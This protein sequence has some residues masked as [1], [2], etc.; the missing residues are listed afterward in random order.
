[1]YWVSGEREW[2]N[3]GMGWFV[4]R[5]LERDGGYTPHEKEK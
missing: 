1:M 2:R 4:G 3:R 5:C